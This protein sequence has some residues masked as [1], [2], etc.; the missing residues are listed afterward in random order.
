MNWNKKHY[1]P[2]FLAKIMAMYIIIGVAFWSKN[3]LF[4]VKPSV[5]V[6]SYSNAD[7]DRILNPYSKSASLKTV[8]SLTPKKRTGKQEPIA[9]ASFSR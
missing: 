1:N 5:K 9:I 4:P 7:K 8:S 3:G 2:P 6:S